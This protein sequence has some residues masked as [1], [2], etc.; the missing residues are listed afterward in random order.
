MKTD[1]SGRAMKG[2]AIHY[3]MATWL[4][5]MWIDAGIRNLTVQKSSTQVKNIEKK[6]ILSRVER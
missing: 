3:I 5:C 1:F 6:S 2:T 4:G